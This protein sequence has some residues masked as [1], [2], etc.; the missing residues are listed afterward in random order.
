LSLHFL[1]WELADP[2][3]LEHL[4]RLDGLRASP[5]FCSLFASH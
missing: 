5:P 2:S 4:D 1:K 3:N